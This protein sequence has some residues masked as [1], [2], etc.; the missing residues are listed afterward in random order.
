MLNINLVK[1]ISMEKQENKFISYHVPP[2]LSSIVDLC[3]IIF[4]YWQVLV[5]FRKGGGNLE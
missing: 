2:K 1:Q 4:T 5:K 3:W